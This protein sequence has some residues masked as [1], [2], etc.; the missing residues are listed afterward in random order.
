MLTLKSLSTPNPLPGYITQ[1]EA[2]SCAAVL[3]HSTMQAS[4]MVA[5]QKTIPPKVFSRAKKVSTSKTRA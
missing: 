4:A 5:P 3:K 1:R 2:L